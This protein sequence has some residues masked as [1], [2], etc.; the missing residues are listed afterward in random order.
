MKGSDLIFDWIVVGGGIS[1]IAVSEMLSRE[2]KSVL[3]LEKNSQ[4]ASETSK[5]FHEWVHSGALYSLVPDNLLTLR[6]LLGATDDIAEYY[7]SFPK[8]N[9]MHTELGIKISGS[10][11]FNRDSI[12]YKYKLHKFNPIWLSLVS[13]SISLIDMINEHDWLRRRAGSEYGSSKIKFQHNFKHIGQ[14]LM[15]RQRFFSKTSPDFTMNSRL[16][17][18]DILSA[19]LNKGLTIKTSSQAEKIIEENNT[20]KVVVQDKV[21]HAKKIVI[22][23]PDAI[24]EML[25]VK[26]KIGYAPMAIAENIPKEEHSFV[27]LDYYV[28]RCINLLKKEDGIGQ[29]GGI[30][31]NHKRDIDSYLAYIITEHKRRN[32]GIK[33]LDTYVG[34]KKEL[35]SKKQDRNY[36]Y[37]IDRP[38]DNIWTIVLG[39]FTLAFSM[40]PEFFRR[41][42]HKNPPKFTESN[43]TFE[44]SKILSPA[45]WQEVINNK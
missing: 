2:D 36:L 13:R 6:Y 25:G 17:I 40:A 29:L 21:Y 20:V 10:G 19:A 44:N 11:W 4:L 33:I 24:S 16:L 39:K 30:T 18:S 3:L 23:S 27:E 41:V 26:M 35:V 28:K 42:Y 15:S 34:L 37:H 38:T 1:G 32:P 9:L 45:K 12:I 14:Q 5:D 43:N 22:C 7:S 8:M 31:L